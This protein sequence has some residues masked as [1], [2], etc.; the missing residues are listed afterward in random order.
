MLFAITLRD[1]TRPF[2]AAKVMLGYGVSFVYA[3]KAL[4]QADLY[5]VGWYTLQ[6]FIAAAA[7][8]AAEHPDDW[9]KTRER[10]GL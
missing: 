3:Y 2:R 4:F 6:E 5:V 8:V 1:V 10:L 9:Q 7:Q